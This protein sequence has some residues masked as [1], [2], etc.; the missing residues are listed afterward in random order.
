MEER[1]FLTDGIVWI[2]LGRTTLGDRE[3]WRLYEQLYHQL[4]S[5]REED[6]GDDDE[7]KDADDNA[8]NSSSGSSGNKKDNNHALDDT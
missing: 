8:S 7:G 3:M 6:L 2:H 4:L 5:C 1:E